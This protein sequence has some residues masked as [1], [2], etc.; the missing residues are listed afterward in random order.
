MQWRG[1]C[2]LNARFSYRALSHS[3]SE[4]CPNALLLED[5]IGLEEDG[6]GIERP[7]ARRLVQTVAKWH[8]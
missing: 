5:R 6:R 3:D 1:K 2:K 8:G 7:R 4:S